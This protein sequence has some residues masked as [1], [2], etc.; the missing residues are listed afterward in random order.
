MSVRALG[1]AL[2]TVPYLA[3]LG[4]TVE[5]ARPGS[6]IL[7]LPAGEQVLDHAGAIHP[8]A[9]FAV[10]E[11]AAGVALGTSPKLTGMVHLQKATGVKYLARA[12]G[13]VRAQAQVDD[14]FVQAVEA[15]LA[16]SSRAEADVVVAVRDQR[17]EIV[18]EVVA[19]YT[20]RAR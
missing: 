12:T 2:G 7:R 19:V 1:E 5:Q 16:R 4:I 6:V 10:G 11:A 14:H 17:G 3:G 13:P 9:L 15:D 8:A 18:A 20:F